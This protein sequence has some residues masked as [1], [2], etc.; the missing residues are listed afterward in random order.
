MGE[1]L[2]GQIPDNI[3]LSIQ[4]LKLKAD[5]VG[6]TGDI[7]VQDDATAFWIK[8][9]TNE[10]LEHGFAQARV[11]FDST[12]L[13]DGE[14]AIESLTPPSYLFVVAGGVI[15]PGDYVKLDT[16]GQKW[17]VANAADLAAG[18]VGGR[19][20]RKIGDNVS[21]AS[22]LDDIIVIKTGVAA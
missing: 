3:F 6:L 22:A 17:I 8:A 14:V 4:Q 13:V 9:S 20:S 15:N 7:I 10:V 16:S 5:V 12:G 19:Y 18:L 11:D 1:P 21:N 2:P